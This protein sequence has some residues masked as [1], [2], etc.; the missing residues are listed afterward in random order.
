MLPV[1][2]FRFSG[3]SISSTI[4][5][6]PKSAEGMQFPDNLGVSDVSGCKRRKTVNLWALLI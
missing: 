6:E 1:F 3:S 2:A 5:E 4:I